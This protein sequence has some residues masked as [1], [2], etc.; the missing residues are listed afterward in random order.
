MNVSIAASKQ[1]TYLGLWSF[2]QMSVAR[3][4]GNDDL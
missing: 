4:Q 2:E 3:P 1:K